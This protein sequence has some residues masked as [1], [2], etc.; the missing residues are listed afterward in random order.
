MQKLINSLLM[1]FIGVFLLVFSLYHL[2]NAQTFQVAGK[3]VTDVDTDEKVVALTFDGGPTEMTED[4]L[5]SLEKYDVQA[6]FFL[7]GSTI[8]KHPEQLKKIVQTNHQIG[9]QSYSYEKMIFKSPSW[10]RQEI[11][12]TDQLIRD[13]GYQGTIPF[14]PPY[15]KKLFVLPFYLQQHER[16]TVMW[17]IEPKIYADIDSEPESIIQDVSDSVEPGSIISLEVMYESNEQYAIET[18]EG[19]IEKLSAKGYTFTSVSE[20]MT[21]QK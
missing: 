20:L 16:D 9:N 11:E 12:T 2:M 8:M 13:A 3:L 6:T 15:G 5:K 1:T 19:I 18:I 17:S 4:I 10:I 7:N 14:R 21:Y